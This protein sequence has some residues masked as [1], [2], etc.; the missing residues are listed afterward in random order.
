MTDDRSLERAARAFIEVGPTQ[1]P[2]RA[3]QAALLRV[4]STSQERD[5]RV[6]WRT[7]HMTRFALA[8]AAAATIVAVI[9]GGAYLLDGQRPPDTGASPSPTAS[10]PVSPSPS[11]TGII[12]SAV[13]YAD[14]PGWI[15]FEHFGQAPDGSTTGFDPDNRMIWLVHADGSDLH[16]LAPGD[17][18]DGKSSPDIS[19]DGTKVV[20]ASWTPRTL[21]WEA[22]IAGG[23]A[24]LISTDCDGQFQPCGEDQ[25]AYSPDG[26]RIAFARS[27]DGLATTEIAIRDLGTGKVTIL[28]STSVASSSGY[29]AQPSW[30]PDGTQLVYHRVYQTP[31][32]ERATDSEV[33]VVGVDDAG[34]SKMPRPSG[35]WAADPDWSPTDGMIVFS[36]S[37]NRETEGWA[38]DNG[39]PRGG[40]WTIRP[41]G[42][43]LSQACG[44]CFGGGVAPSWTPDGRQIL[45][46][47][48]RSF[49]LVNPDGS[50]I[51]HI[52]QPALTWYGDQLGYG[53]AAFL[54]PE[55]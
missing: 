34:L 16:E 35:S 55:P 12:D 31:S 42:S 44:E 30:S 46:W 38:F 43:G 40:I 28:R 19:P 26:S 17:P 1:A 2:D 4:Q 41:D 39:A 9:L 21:I 6:P 32:D 8:G 3:V 27:S 37:P 54:A 10:S 52:N 22:D 51:A 13:G 33:F 45:F 5:L 24:R 50:G 25:P 11:S 15:V 7:P 18:A 48:Y 23:P 53:Y 36:T 14:L 29:V 49:A 47:G 20:F